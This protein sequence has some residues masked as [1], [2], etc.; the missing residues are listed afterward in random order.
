MLLAITDILGVLVGIVALAAGI[1]VMI[2]KLDPLIRKW[3]ER[4]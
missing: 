3:R 4:G 1:S 2:E